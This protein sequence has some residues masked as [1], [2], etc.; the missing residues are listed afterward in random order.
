MAR[1]WSNVK[2]PPAISP[3]QR[4]KTGGPN[5]LS[6]YTVLLIVATVWFFGLIAY[7]MAHVILHP[8]TELP[9][10]HVQAPKED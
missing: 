2:R 1:T 10:V 4:A 7:T 3:A 8:I 6:I 5:S 9:Q